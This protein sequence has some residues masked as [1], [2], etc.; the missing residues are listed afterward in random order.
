MVLKW[1][2]WILRNNMLVFNQRYV[3]NL[4]EAETRNESIKL[5]QRHFMENM[6]ILMEKS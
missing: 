5:E 6:E 1:F 4:T 2:Q 3:P